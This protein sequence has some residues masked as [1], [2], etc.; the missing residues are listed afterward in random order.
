MDLCKFSGI[1][2]AEAKAGMI[3]EAFLK[4]GRIFL[5]GYITLGVVGSPFVPGWIIYYWQFD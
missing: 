5:I 4:P 3:Q 1:L 2:H